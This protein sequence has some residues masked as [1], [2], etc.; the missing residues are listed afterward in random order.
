[1]LELR[2][3]T[4]RVGAETHIDDVSLSFAPG[5]LNI[6]LGPTLSGKTSLMRLM[7]GLDAPA[8]GRIIFEGADVTGVPVQRR[9]VAMVYQQFINYPNLSVYENI[10]SPLRVAGAQRAEM[11][12]RV[13]DTAAMM[14]LTP[15]LERKPL[16][17]SG[18]Q[19]QR[20]A[21]PAPSSRAATLVLPDEPLANL[22]YKLREELREEVTRASSPL[23][24]RYT[25][26]ATTGARRR[27][28]CLGGSTPTLWQGRVTPVGPT[29]VVY[30]RPDACKRR[31]LSRPAESY[32]AGAKVR[33]RL[34]TALGGQLNLPA[35]GCF[36][37]NPP[38]ALHAWFSPRHL[39]LSAGPDALSVPERS[40][41]RRS[42]A[43]KVS[44]TSMSPASAGWRWPTASTI[45]ASASRS[46]SFSIRPASSYSTHPANSPPRRAPCGGPHRWRASCSTASPTPTRPRRAGR[47]IMR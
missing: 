36:C 10:A 46:S 35:N 8:E 33:R 4:K 38:T 14:K 18:G 39:F 15:L 24:C 34:L 22:D 37:R 3:V 1:M 20:S 29:V 17:L 6:L 32:G 27:R 40:P 2:G 26:T 21:L 9:S 11:D 43:Q 47:R 44:S 19:Q 13:R 45:S 7:A 23:R 30:R 25:S 16:E 28:C 42:P 5:T 31:H 12:K 41:L